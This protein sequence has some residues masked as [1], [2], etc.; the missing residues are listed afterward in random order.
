MTQS[1]FLILFENQYNL[2]I[3]L[4][5]GKSNFHIKVLH[6]FRNY[7]D[8]PVFTC[9]KKKGVYLNIYRQFGNSCQIKSV[10]KTTSEI[11]D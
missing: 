8:L 3:Q 10:L 9:M 5:V 2:E 1:D 6:S 11:R 4:L 7:N